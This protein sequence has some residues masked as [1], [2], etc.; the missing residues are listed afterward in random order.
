MLRTASRP[1]ISLSD[2]EDAIDV[3]AF[4]NVLMVMPLLCAESSNDISS[5]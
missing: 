4:A 1:N 5:N 3:A 2:E